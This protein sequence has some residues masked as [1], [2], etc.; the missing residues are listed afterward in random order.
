MGDDAQ[1][2]VIRVNSTLNN[3]ENKIQQKFMDV[4]GLT[5]IDKGSTTSIEMAEKVREFY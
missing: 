5:R 4:L 3:S 1:L 2:Q